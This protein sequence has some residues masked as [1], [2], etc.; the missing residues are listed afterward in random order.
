MTSIRG[1]PAS[2]RVGLV[3]DMLAGWHD[4]TTPYQMLLMLSSCH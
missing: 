1:I 3:A 2:I 4:A